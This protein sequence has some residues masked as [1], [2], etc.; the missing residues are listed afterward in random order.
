MTPCASERA[1][2]LLARPGA[3]LA[4]AGDAYAVRLGTDRRAR[5]VMSLDEAV[6]LRLV[7]APGLRPRPG[8]GWRLADAAPGAEGPP[9]GRPGLCEGERAVMTPEGALRPVR[10]NLTPTAIAWL[11][12][13][14]DADGR[15]WLTPAEV[16]AGARLTLD[17]ELARRGPGLT[18]R[19]D[20]LPRAGRGGG[21]GFA[22]PGE[23]ALEARR[24]VVRALEAA[25]LETRS[26]LV[27]VCVEGDALRAAE[28]ALGLRA[29][30]GRL[31]L[32][33]GLRALTRHYGVG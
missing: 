9:P 26:V 22:G 33:A 28:N 13:R 29:R 1:R 8:G 32:I 20:P 18:F 23:G 14:R 17:A 21:T 10:A 6:F 11:A 25:P 2:R 16:A 24:R 3:W 7:E 5:V 15:P 31:R 27:R 4:A 12:R 30:Q 19:W